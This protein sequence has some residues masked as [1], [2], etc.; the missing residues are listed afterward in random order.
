MVRARVRAQRGHVFAQ[1]TALILDLNTGRGGR[2]YGV[3]ALGGQQAREA[4]G[5]GLA[6]AATLSGL[7]TTE[8]RTLLNRTQQ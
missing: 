8:W 6:P 3:V 1:Q 4:A 5:V 2:G 7:L